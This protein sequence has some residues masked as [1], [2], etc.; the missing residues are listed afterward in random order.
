MM[1]ERSLGSGSSRPGLLGAAGD[2]QAARTEAAAGRRGRELPV[3]GAV[4]V[5]EGPWHPAPMGAIPVMME[6]PGVCG[7]FFPH[8][9]DAPGFGVLETSNGAGWFSPL[10][11]ASW[12]HLRD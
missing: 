7:S 5:R 10:F 3:Q 4:V 1:E 2:R 11:L 8:P 9:A 12:V 6:V